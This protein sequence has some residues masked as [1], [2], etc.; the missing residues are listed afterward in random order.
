MAQ[1]KAAYQRFGI[2]TAVITVIYVVYSAIAAARRS[3][4]ASLLPHKAGPMSSFDGISDGN[5][6][7]AAAASELRNSNAGAVPAPQGQ[8]KDV[9]DCL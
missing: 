1:D 6:G 2:W 4:L 7:A 8:S 3:D 9:T 5:V